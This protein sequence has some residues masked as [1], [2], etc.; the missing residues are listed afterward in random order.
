[1]QITMKTPIE[2]LKEQGWKPAKLARAL[3][4]IGKNISPQA[5]SQWGEVPAERLL[6]VERVTGVPRQQLRPDLYEGMG[7]VA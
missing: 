3:T 5:I 4:D 6:D 1:M 2:N 7:E